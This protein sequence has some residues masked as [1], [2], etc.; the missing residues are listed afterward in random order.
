ME[1]PHD[2]QRCM[3]QI[4][5]PLVPNRLLDR[6]VVRGVVRAVITTTGVVDKVGVDVDVDVGLGTPGVG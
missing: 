6:S 4:P 2:A 1:E 5:G 3:V